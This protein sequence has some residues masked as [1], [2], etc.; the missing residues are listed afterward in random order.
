MLIAALCLHQSAT[1]PFEN[2]LFVSPLKFTLNLVLIFLPCSGMN[3]KDVVA[4]NRRYSETAESHPI[5]SQMHCVN[6][7]RH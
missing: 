7:L 4:F 5:N 2:N 6:K 3:N 1:A